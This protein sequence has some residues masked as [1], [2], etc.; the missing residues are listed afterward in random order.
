MRLVA[1]NGETIVGTA[2]ASRLNDGSAK[3][4]QIYVLPDVQG[5]GVGAAL[6][7]AV[8]DELADVNRLELEVE[9]QNTAA[10]AFYARWG[11][12]EVGKI[13]DCGRPGSGISALLMAKRRPS[14]S[15]SGTTAP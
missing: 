7:R 9:P 8:I 13:A 4:H 2:A 12:V 11:F 3:L 1:L 15:P 5:A 10:R 14:N 6:L